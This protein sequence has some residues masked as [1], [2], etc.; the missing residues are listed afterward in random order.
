MFKIEFNDETL[1]IEFNNG[2]Y[3]ASVDGYVFY[4]DV[5]YETTREVLLAG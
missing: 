1:A 2:V 5:D 3:E 4:S